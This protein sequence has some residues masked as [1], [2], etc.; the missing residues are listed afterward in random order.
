MASGGGSRQLLRWSRA[1]DIGR[2]RFA[3]ASTSFEELSMSER[4]NIMSNAEIKADGSDRDG[5]HL[6]LVRTTDGLFWFEADEELAQNDNDFWLTVRNFGL[7]ER[8]L[9]GST[10][11]M[12]RRTFTAAEARTARSRLEAFF[13]GPTDT[14]GL[15]YFYRIRRGK[16]L[17]VNFPPDWIT[18]AY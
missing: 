12:L 16:C 11:P 6:Y 14:P 9:A 13:G 7:P 5:I 3:R 15:P 4:E 17:G 1:E 18:V 8:S 2:R 10:D